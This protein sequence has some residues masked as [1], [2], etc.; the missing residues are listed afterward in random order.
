MAGREKGC[1]YNI[2]SVR[3]PIKPALNSAATNVES[4]HT[5]NVEVAAGLV[6]GE[7]E[8]ARDKRVAQIQA[9]FRPVEEAAR[10][11]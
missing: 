10:A 9:M 6:K 1:D 3:S 11:L 7:Y 4:L 5:L 8:M 2:D